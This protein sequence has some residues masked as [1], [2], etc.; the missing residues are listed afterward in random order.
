M[1]RRGPQDAIP[2]NDALLSR[3]IHDHMVRDTRTLSLGS[4]A[5]NFTSSGSITND[6]GRE[7]GE[8]RHCTD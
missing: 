4:L 8:Q 3:L 6:D 5:R 2:T 7:F 1:L